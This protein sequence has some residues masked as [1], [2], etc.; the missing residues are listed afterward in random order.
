MLSNTAFQI[1]E[2]VRKEIA[3]SGMEKTGRPLAVYITIKFVGW[4]FHNEGPLIQ[5]LSLH[6][7]NLNGGIQKL[8][9]EKFIGYL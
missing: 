9:A 6:V 7:L 8:D 2:E 5:I 1:T 4:F 3:C